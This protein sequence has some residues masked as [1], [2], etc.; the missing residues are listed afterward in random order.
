MIK[1]SQPVT[2][3]WKGDELIKL[4][5]TAFDDAN[6]VLERRFA[7]EFVKHK[8]DWPAE[9]QPAPRDID[10][11]GTLRRSQRK[12]KSAPNEWSWSWN[13][14]YAVFVHNGVTFRR[15]PLAG[16]SFPAR[17]WTLKPIEDLPGIFNTLVK[18]A[19]SQL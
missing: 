7:T 8:W 12:V 13:M 4:L 6:Q 5:E 2:E 3:Q 11:T 17:P 16:K 9:W 10:D 1:I 14:T 15:G 18:H 19:M